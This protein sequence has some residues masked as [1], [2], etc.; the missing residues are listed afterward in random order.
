MSASSG[1]FLI[2]PTLLSFGGGLLSATLLI[3]SALCYA[4]WTQAYTSTYE[5]WLL[6]GLTLVI[7]GYLGES[8]SERLCATDEC[9]Y[10]DSLLRPRRSI[11]IK[12]I[13]SCVHVHEGLNMARGIESVVFTLRDQRMHTFSLGPLWRLRDLESFFRIL[14][15]RLHPQ[16]R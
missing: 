2:R 8:G 11:A 13:A 14:E 9:V 12:D 4:A 16:Q 7:A 10:T 1:T 6:L 3:V 15:E 5:R